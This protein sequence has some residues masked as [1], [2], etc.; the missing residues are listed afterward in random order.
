MK[1]ENL[2]HLQTVREQVAA[3]EAK[4]RE[5]VEASDKSSV[6]LRGP[7]VAQEQEKLQKR[8][9]LVAELKAS[10]PALQGKVASVQESNR[11]LERKLVFGENMELGKEL[12][13]TKKATL[14]AESELEGARLELT[15]IELKSEED[16]EERIKKACKGGKNFPKKATEFQEALRV[17]GSASG[18]QIFELSRKV[19]H[20]DRSFANLSTLQNEAE[21][22][23]VQQDQSQEVVTEMKTKSSALVEL[24]CEGTRLEETRD[25]LESELQQELDTCS[26]RGDKLEHLVK[27]LHKERKDAEASISSDRQRAEELLKQLCPAGEEAEDCSGSSLAVRGARKVAT[28]LRAGLAEI[29]RRVEGSCMSSF[30]DCVPQV[31]VPQSASSQEP[32]S[33]GR[34]SLHEALRRA[35]DISALELCL[36]RADAL[37]T[38][39]A[40]GSAGAGS[41]GF[42]RHQGLQAC[43]LCFKA[44]HCAAAAAQALISL[45]PARPGSLTLTA[46][47]AS[48]QSPE[49]RVCFVNGASGE[50]KWEDAPEEESLVLAESGSGSALSIRRSDGWWLDMESSS[51]WLLVWQKEDE[52]DM[53]WRRNLSKEENIWPEEGFTS[54]AA[55]LG[56]LLRAVR[57]RQPLEEKSLEALKTLKDQ[58]SAVY[59]ANSGTVDACVVAP[60]RAAYALR[61]TEGAY[62]YGADLAGQNGMR[63]LAVG[64]PAPEQQ[65]AEWAQLAARLRPLADRL[66]AIGHA[67]GFQKEG[68]EVVELEDMASRHAQ[69]IEKVIMKGPGDVSTIQALHS[70]VRK[71]KGA[72][73]DL[74]RV[75]GL[76]E[77]RV[78]RP[79]RRAIEHTP[80]WA[81]RSVAA[82]Q[83]YNAVTGMQRRL[84]KVSGDTKERQASLNTATL[85]LTT[86]SSDIVHRRAEMAEMLQK[87]SSA[88]LTAQSKLA[89]QVAAEASVKEKALQQELGTV[90]ARRDKEGSQRHD[91]MSRVGELEEELRN[92]R[93]PWDADDGRT[94]A[95]DLATMWQMRVKGAR[96]LYEWQVSR[97]ETLTPLPTLPDKRVPAMRTLAESSTQY[98]ALQKDLLWER[99]SARLARLPEEN[100]DFPVLAEP[101]QEQVGRMRELQ[102]KAAHIRRVAGPDIGAPEDGGDTASAGGITR[103]GLQ[104]DVEAAATAPALQVTV[105]MGV[106]KWATAVMGTAKVRRFNVDF[107]QMFGI[108]DSLVAGQ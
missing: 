22:L 94:S 68:M 15:T 88:E 82:R 75:P 79:R 1:P 20:L 97:V 55:L 24:L 56:Q 89:C 93:R 31:W 33:G 91:L 18:K 51:A 35:D 29:E 105:Q 50:A 61:Q 14:S 99:S 6:G 108:H 65:Q 32:R 25:D 34:K 102:V 66:R 83:E 3:K 26:T 100:A 64:E 37:A 53:L 80:L 77:R 92:L 44:C 2:Q 27:E 41:A 104:K 16:I 74:E 36:H 84:N 103:P 9:A 54:G 21:K 47:S 81:D 73:D 85:S 69:L 23:T 8:E 107:Q 48:W 49:G 101:M 46:I 5:L 4:Y 72:L 28:S 71:V 67:G 43:Q 39:T 95:T 59:L 58:F 10:L 40:K 62:N 76:V 78:V 13:E 106:P 38:Y 96:E 52:E 45:G 7:E 70:S 11:T 57:E 63:P 30:K 98:A 86:D 60:F 12:F 90:R 42:V 87:G 17:L 19:E